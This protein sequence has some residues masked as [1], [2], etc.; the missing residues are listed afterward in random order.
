MGFDEDAP[1]VGREA[2]ASRHPRIPANPTANFHGGKR[3][4]E[5]HQSTTS[6]ESRLYRKSRTQE[7]KLAYCGNV[8]TE[9]RNGLI[10]D[11]RV[12]QADGYAERRGAL[13]MLDEKVPNHKGV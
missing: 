9:N 4:N 3:S 2:G 5:T 11:L 10:V 7:A 1:A 6:P 8:L 12:E 13:A